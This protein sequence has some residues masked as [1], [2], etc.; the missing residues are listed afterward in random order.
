[1]QAFILSAGEGRRL[2][3]YTKVLPKSLFPII[4]KP[5]LEI[6]LD[7]LIYSGFRKIGINAYHLKDKLLPFIKEYQRK[8]LQVEIEVF[9]EPYLLG[10]GGALLNAR[11][12][13]KEPTLVI[14]GDI[15]TNF[16]LKTF[17]FYHLNQNNPITI[18]CFKGHNDN[19]EIESNLVKNFRIASKNAYTYAGIQVINPEIFK[20]FPQ[21]KDLIKIYQMLIFNKKI[22]INSF[23]TQGYYLKDIGTLERYLS[24]FED[25][26][27]HKISIPFLNNNFSSFQVIKTK[28]I[29]KNLKIENWVYI[30]EETLIEEKTF[31]SKVVS[32][33]KAHIRSGNY[34]FQLFI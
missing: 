4:G 9:V 21:E 30:E 26:L 14:N 7:Q 17:Y 28:K 8:H 29:P 25:L 22:S 18:L 32:W 19:V 3:P 34:E 5:L 13:F 11:T 31:L 33:K 2:L 12:F 1:M 20:Y 27:V 15:L 16:P 24:C 10:T 23:I 6:I